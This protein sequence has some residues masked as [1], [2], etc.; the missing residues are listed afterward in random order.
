MIDLTKEEIYWREQHPK[1]PPLTGRAPKRRTNILARVFWKLRTTS[2]SI[3]SDTGLEQ[4]CLGTM[5]DT[6]S[7]RLG[8]SLAT[9]SA[10]GISV[11]EF[12]A[13]SDYS[14]RCFSTK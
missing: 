12:A 4:R 5:Q 8:R 3:T 9:I 6:R 11:V 13:D 2:C 10:R 7:T 14:R 1:H